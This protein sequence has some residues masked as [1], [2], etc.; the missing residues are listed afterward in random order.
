[1]IDGLGTGGTERSLADMLPGLR[2]SGVTASLACL[3]QRGRGV[4]SS[5]CEAGF[6]VTFLEGRRL[7]TRARG[8]AQLIRGHRP[9][10]IHSM[11]FDATLAA[12]LAALVTRVPQITSL[13]NTSYDPVRFKDPRVG[14]WR[15]RLVQAVDALSARLTVHFHAVTRAV[16]DAAVEQLHLDPGRVTVIYR[17][18][19]LERLGRSSPERRQSI[20]ASLGLDQDTPIVL[21]VG[22]QEFQKGQIYLLQAF[23]KLLVR[24]PKAYLLIAGRP[25]AATAE[26]QHAAAELRLVERVRFLGYREDVPD[27]LAAADVFAFPSLFEGIGGAILEAMALGLPVVASRLDGLA[28]VVTDGLDGL[29]VP[30]AD[31]SSLA[32]A[33]GQV[34][35]RGDLR[36]ALAS[37]A[38]ETVASRF[39]LGVSVTRTIEMYERVL[40]QQAR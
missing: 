33:I 15:L 35:E 20:R 9:D 28:E 2:D 7:V 23:G 27:L 31:P 30:P 11:I 1:M 32:A 22:R 12:R 39:D 37:R 8:L 5:V 18:R 10:L 40:R 21:S 24:Q 4:E 19:N 13:V 29:L 6:P 3:H 14:R 38:R 26:L 25:G 17:G 36:T 34:L 16:R